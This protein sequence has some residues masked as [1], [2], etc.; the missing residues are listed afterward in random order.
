M[1]PKLKLSK[2][3]KQVSTLLVVLYTLMQAHAFG[4]NV[5]EDYQNCF[6]LYL[7]T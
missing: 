1:V 4:Y 3:E 2:G 6:S 7:Y 5:Y